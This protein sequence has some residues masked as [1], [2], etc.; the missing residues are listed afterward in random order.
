M[1][2]MICRY[3]EIKKYYN[4]ILYDY[5]IVQNWKRQEFNF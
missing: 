1:L 3:K 5:D 4:V 2:R